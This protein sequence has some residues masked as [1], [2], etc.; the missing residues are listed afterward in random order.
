MT[1]SFTE[2]HVLSDHASSHWRSLLFYL[3]EHNTTLR[4]SLESVINK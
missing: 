2:E 4:Q 3:I 1:A